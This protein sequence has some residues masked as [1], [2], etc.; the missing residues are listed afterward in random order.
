MVIIQGIIFQETGEP[1]PLQRNQWP[2]KET[3]KLDSCLTQRLGTARRNCFQGSRCPAARNRCSKKLGICT[4]SWRTASHIFKPSGPHSKHQSHCLSKHAE[5]REAPHGCQH[6]NCGSRCT[7]ETPR[8]KSSEK[9]QGSVRNSPKHSKYYAVPSHVP[10]S[11]CIPEAKA[12]SYLPGW[13][14]VAHLTKPPVLLGIH[15]NL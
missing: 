11:L 14:L 5:L 15:I 10:W 4:A 3:E 2:G 1:Y 13:N 9:V 12:L 8:Q 6:T 7:S